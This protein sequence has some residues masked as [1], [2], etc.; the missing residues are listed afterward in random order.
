V[1]KAK[2][3]VDEKTDVLFPAGW[4]ERKGSEV[5]AEPSRRKISVFHPDVSAP[6]TCMHLGVLHLRIQAL[7]G[8]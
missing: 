5:L 3:G 6:L 8:V 1:A 4:L 7:S 2:S